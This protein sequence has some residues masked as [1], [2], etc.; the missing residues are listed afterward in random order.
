MLYLM[1]QFHISNKEEKNLKLSFEITCAP[2][3]QIPTNKP[4][5][6]TFSDLVV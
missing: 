1:R 4:F 2:E 3:V 5:L 6:I